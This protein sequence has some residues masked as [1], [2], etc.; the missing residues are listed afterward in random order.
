M[1]GART[2]NTCSTHWAQNRHG[3]VHVVTSYCMHPHLA[4]PLPHPG[5]HVQLVC[6]LVLHRSL[7]LCFFSLSRE[8]SRSLSIGWLGRFSHTYHL[9]ASLPPACLPACLSAALS[10][11]QPGSPSLFGKARS[12]RSSFRRSAKGTGPAGGAKR[13]QRKE[14]DRMRK[15]AISAPL[16][17]ANKRLSRSLDI[18]NRPD[19]QSTMPTWGEEGAEEGEGH[20]QPRRRASEMP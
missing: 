7:P 10:V 19:A 8:L 13:E 11:A 18:L 4:S 6:H 12:F 3:L 15:L 14:A 9:P 1:L 20:T 5:S 17:V 2:R 16:S